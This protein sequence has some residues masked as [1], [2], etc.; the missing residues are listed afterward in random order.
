M[1]FCGRRRATDA[2]HMGESGASRPFLLIFNPEKKI[3]E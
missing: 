3:R 1:Y 2:V